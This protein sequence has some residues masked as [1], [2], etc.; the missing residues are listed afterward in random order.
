MP[1]RAG[2]HREE[3][4]LTRLFGKSEVLLSKARE[5]D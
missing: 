5:R 3:F 1:S 2:R 4:D